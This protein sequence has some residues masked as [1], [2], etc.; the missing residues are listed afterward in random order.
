MDQKHYFSFIFGHLRLGMQK[1]CFRSMFGWIHRCEG[2]TVFTKKNPHITVQTHCSRANYTAYWGR[3]D[4]EAPSQ[5]FLGWP[6]YIEKNVLLIHW[7]LHSV[8]IMPLYVIQTD[9]GLLKPNW[10]LSVND[11]SGDISI[12]TLGNTIHF[13]FF[14]F[15]K[16]DSRLTSPLQSWA[17]PKP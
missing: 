12:S 1:Y 3:R 11:S 10:P 5:P 4:P 7:A 15:Y 2:P 6:Q 8:C 13:C 16:S 17:L 9:V 14:S